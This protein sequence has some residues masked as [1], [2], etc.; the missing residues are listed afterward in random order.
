V[1]TSGNDLVES[2]PAINTGD[3]LS[4]AGV[5]PADKRRPIWR[6]A[7]DFV[8]PGERIPWA[9]AGIVLA[10]LLVYGAMAA[11]L[12][13]PGGFPMEALL[14][15]GA[16]F[17]PLTLRGQWW[18]LF[19]ALFLHLNLAHLL[20]N[21]WV[22]CRIG[23]LAERL[24]GRTMMLGL[25]LAA[26]VLSSLT[27]LAWDP[28]VTSAGASGAIFGVF[29]SLVALM[30]HPGIRI[31]SA[32]LR[33]RWLSM[34]VFLLYSLVS[35]MLQS[36]I[37]N[38]AHA[39]GL[40]TGFVLSWLLIR[41]VSVVEAFPKRQPLAA[42]VFVG[43]VALAALW[44]ANASGARLTPSGQF[45][46]DHAWFATGESVNLREWQRLGAQSSAGT[47]SSVELAQ[48]FER[49][50]LP[51]WQ[52]TAR[53][54]H[55]ELPSINGPQRNIAQLLGDYV[56]RRLEWIRAIIQAARHSDAEHLRAVEDLGRQTDLALARIERVELRERMDQRPRSVRNSRW[57][58]QMRDWLL[59]YRWQCA[60][61]SDRPAAMKGALK[62]DANQAAAAGC[63]AQRLFLAG[64]YG[65]LDSLM[66]EY[67]ISLGDL[68]DGGSRFEAL[69]RG[70]DAL[71]K[72][73][74]MQVTEVLER[75]ADW[76][77]AVR[78]PVNADLIEAMMFTDWAWTARGHGTA[79]TV[80]AS[81][82]ASFAHRTE[83]AAATL[84]A[85]QARAVANPLWYK[86]SI[87]IGLDQTLDP[88]RI[89]AIFQAGI[90]R[91][92]H[93]VA[94]Y[95]AMLRTLMPRWGG[96]YEKVDELI[97]QGASSPTLHSGIDAT[98]YAELYWRYAALEGDDTNIF[99]DARADWEIMRAGLERMRE[100]HPASN[101]I[102][103]AY[104]RFACLADD[105]DRYGNVRPSLA[106]RASPSV[107]SQKYTLQAC[108]RMMADHYTSEASRRLD[109]GDF[110][111]AIEQ[112]NAALAL[113][114]KSDRALADRGMARIWRNQ[115]E[116]AR[117]D[118]D[119]AFALNLHNVVVFHGRGILAMQ[120]GHYQEAVAAMDQA[121]LEKPDD[122]F[123]LRWRAQAYEA[124]GE[125][126]LALADSTE[127]L[128]TRPD[129]PDMHLLR[130]GIF[131]RQGRVSD[132]LH[133]AEAL[134][135]RDTKDPRV[136]FEAGAIYASLRQ[137]DKAMH[138]LDRAVALSP[139]A[140]GYLNRARYRP[141]EDLDGRRADIA[142][143]LKVDPTSVPALAMRAS[144]QV[145]AAQYRQAVA[146]VEAAINITGATP[147]LLVLRGVAHAKSGEAT[148]AA[149]DF[150][151]AR[152]QSSTPGE[153]N[154]LCW[155]LGTENI[156]LE[157]A[158]SACDAA[159][160]RAPRNPAIIDSRGFVLLRLG[161]YDAAIAAYDDALR[162][163][164]Y[165][166]A[167]LYGRGIARR[168]RSDAQGGAA[169]L[170]AALDL[171]PDI[172]QRFARYGVKR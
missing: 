170:R 155:T 104:A 40:V 143:A 57:L 28:T 145:H 59:S 20:V 25:Y 69:T 97:R 131:R 67:A 13:L 32:L 2:Q 164:P 78:S 30:L 127:V 82:W 156:A 162:I 24:H 49:D 75:T 21:M 19:S 53:R 147:E 61:A 1:N 48:R 41:P 68:P 10:N 151:D 33:A 100:H 158:L 9:T 37:D 23:P 99:S 91:F 58:A 90:V 34:L 108:D 45:L 159:V 89:R 136:W 138:A 137:N 47:V 94:L 62:D 83:M 38:A 122:V 101:L 146:T 126:A 84:R 27:S 85:I 139:T 152:A 72:S 118:L 86:L 106:A 107:W 115:P 55:A 149:N 125:H 153:L 26:G 6:D 43:A 119:A 3:L 150:D 169:D 165:L 51:F 5:S 17:G 166:A 105:A 168:H 92:P 123:A 124:L 98:M 141:S 81:A 161:Q 88:A 79:D 114:A 163:Q 144:M 52:S 8:H 12:H 111:G 60:G 39:G 128:R 93:D 102:L 76:R 116:Q 160:T 63:R 112:V 157:T 117:A 120:A 73:G 44:Q 29:G 54:L 113:D 64:A 135:E 4:H 66:D 154:N 129:L 42:G 35:G 50:I 133:E 167:S 65:Q 142:A 109:R 172:A 132:V 148:L 95:G 140:A 18:R 46:H 16:N 36:G 96:S 7:A 80:S 11:K 121:L 77:A 15:W 71:L 74:Q 130:A 103:N 70:L 171:D 134:T 110:R 56:Q 31:P 22:L 14:D 87:S